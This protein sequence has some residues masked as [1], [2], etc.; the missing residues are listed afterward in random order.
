MSSKPE[1]YL[2]WAG[3]TAAR[4]AVEKWHYSQS[5]PVGKTVKIGVWEDRKFIG[6]VLF[7]RGANNNIGKPYQLAQTE[8]CEL[9]R[10][11]LQ[12]H[13]TP[14]TRII[15]IALRMLMQQSP[16][17]RLVVS[18]AD[19][20]QGH[21][22]GIYQGGNWLYS[23]V[24]DTDGGQMVFGRQMHRKTVRSKY[25]TSSLE[26]L[27]KNIDPNATAVK[28]LPKHRYLMP[29][30]KEMAK[31][32]AHLAKEYPKR[33]K[34]AMDVPTSQRRGS[35]DLH[36]PVKPGEQAEVEGSGENFPTIKKDAA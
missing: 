24:S 12:E 27:R 11:A 20:N 26:W 32:I 29:L 34:Q 3:H 4:F 2:N 36:A 30:D 25:G 35:T 22:G 16:G 17:V 31:Q 10:V 33:E 5:L 23:G 6:V 14:V 28:A 21:H 1:L 19:A 18:Y 9:V 8:V 13:G 15:K 7:S